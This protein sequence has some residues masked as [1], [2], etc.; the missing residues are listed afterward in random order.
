MSLLVLPELVPSVWN[1][2]HKGTLLLLGLVLGL[3]APQTTGVFL[4]AHGL[5]FAGVV[6]LVIAVVSMAS[7]RQPSRR[8]STRATSA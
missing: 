4:L 1:A 8:L 6:W 3:A 2:D 5:A 7:A